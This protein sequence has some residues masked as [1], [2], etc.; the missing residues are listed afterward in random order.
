M[1]KLHNQSIIQAKAVVHQLE[2]KAAQV[3]S[4]N[5][6]IWCSTK[7]KTHPIGLWQLFIN[8]QQHKA[9]NTYLISRLFAFAI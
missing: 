4:I 9:P 7:G 2:M 1:L 8:H 6:A 3:G 5:K